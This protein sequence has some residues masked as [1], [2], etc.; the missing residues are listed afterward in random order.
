MQALAQLLEFEEEFHEPAFK[1]ITTA[2]AAES[3]FIKLREARFD[4]EK[5]V[6]DGPKSV[7]TYGSEFKPIHVLEPLLGMHP[8][9]SAMQQQLREGSRFPLDHLTE[10]ARVGDLVGRLLRG[11]HKSAENNMTFLETAMKKEVEKGWLLPLPTKHARDIPN[12]ELAPLGVAIHIGINAQGRFVEKE[13][14]THDLSFPGEFQSH[15]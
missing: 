9:W 15:Q 4:L 11:N 5:M 1:F 2:E 13:R 8:R 10:E 6:N 7:L 12:L 3:S 14:V